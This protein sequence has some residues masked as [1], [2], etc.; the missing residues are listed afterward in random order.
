[1]TKSDG[2]MSQTNVWLELKKSPFTRKKLMHVNQGQP[3]K[4]VVK[5]LINP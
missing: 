3:I 4:E 5:Q 1:M 2:K